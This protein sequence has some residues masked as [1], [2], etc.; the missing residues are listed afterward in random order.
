[1]KKICCRNP[2]LDFELILDEPETTSLSVSR[3]EVREGTMYA[4]DS[5]ESQKR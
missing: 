4:P 1:M 3:I 5:V 2:V